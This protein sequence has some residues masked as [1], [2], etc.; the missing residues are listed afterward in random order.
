MDIISIKVSPLI[1]NYKMGRIRP[2]FIYKKQENDADS[3]FIHIENCAQTTCF[4]HTLFNDDA[5]IE[6]VNIIDVNI[7]PRIV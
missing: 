1:R 5:I 7:K 2:H 4:D 6:Y 3:D